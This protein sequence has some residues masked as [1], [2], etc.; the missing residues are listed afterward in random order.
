MKKFEIPTVIT[1]KVTV[2][3]KG[4]LQIEANSKEEALEKAK[5]SDPVDLLDKVS[6]DGH[7]FEAELDSDDVYEIGRSAELIAS[8]GEGERCDIYIEDIDEVEEIE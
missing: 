1:T 4:F 2:K 8:G 3:V 6:D 5:N 7:D